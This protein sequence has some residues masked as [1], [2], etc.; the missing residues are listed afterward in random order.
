MFFEHIRTALSA[1]REDK[2]RPKPARK[3]ADEYEFQPGHLEISERPPSALSRYTAFAL[4]ALVIITLLWSVIGKLDINAN[5]TGRLMVT[6]RSKVV[7]SVLPGEITAIN[8]R[9]GKQVKA[10][11]LLISLNP[12]GTNSEIKEISQQLIYKKLEKSQLQALLNTKISENNTVSPLTVFKRP[13]GATDEQVNLAKKDLQSDWEEIK[14]NLNRL[15]SDML[16]N[17]TNQRAIED[18]IKT[19]SALAENIKIRLDASQVLLAKGQ[20]PRMEFLSQEKEELEYMSRLT[21][22]QGQLFVLQAQEQNLVKQ[23]H[24]YLS[25]I[26]RSNYDALTRAEVEIAVLQQQLI[27]LEDKKR[28]LNLRAPVDGVVQQL[29]VATL[30]GAVQPADPLMV[31]VPDG[32]L[33]EVEALILNKDVGFV[34]S[35]Q[36]VEI[37]I[38]A[39][40]YTR[41]GTI[42]GKVVNVSKDAV[43]NEQYGLVFPTRI[44]LSKNDLLINGSKVPLQAGMSIV[45]EIHT[46][47]RR[48]ID[49]LLSPLQQYQS[50]ALRER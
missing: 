11:D 24:S 39:F 42:K 30:G 37:K 33:L 2:R 23:R 36:S 5:A 10:G 21:E 47:K 44:S 48:V 41:Y 1:W 20:V 14:A 28:Q 15:D 22:K 50:E 32:E 31:I 35:G 43:E 18:E 4:T 27:Q 46:G 38:D 3:T 19:L 26:R 13:D 9:E 34:H 49:Y 16:V 8:V 29:A 45:A 12:V 6:S 25:E 40:P 7:Q 17:K